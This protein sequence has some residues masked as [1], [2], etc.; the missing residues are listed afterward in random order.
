[1]PIFRT[2]DNIFKDQGEYFDANWMDS[3][4]L[5]LPPNQEWDYKREMIIE[6]VDIW[7]VIAEVSGLGV[8]AAWQPYAEFY[9]LKMPDKNKTETFYGK[10]SQKRL[11]NNLKS[12][13]ISLKLHNRWVD[14][15]KLWLYND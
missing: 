6:D 14:T 3:D 11:Y 13:G 15:D 12:K 9:L 4:S 5:I 10:Q 2:T 1:M 7:E 8:Y